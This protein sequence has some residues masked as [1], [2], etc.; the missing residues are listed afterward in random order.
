MTRFR[1]TLVAAAVVSVAASSPSRPRRAQAPKRGGV[2]RVA[3]QSDPVGFDTLGKKKAP[4]YTQLALAY[5]HNRLLKYDPLGRGRA[6]IS[7]RA[8]RSRTRPPTSSRS[9]RAC[10]S[11]TSRRSTA[12]S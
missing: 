12:A 7:P 9:A 6:T 11:T 10:T 5:T 3:E 4:V 8:G 2:L 1:R